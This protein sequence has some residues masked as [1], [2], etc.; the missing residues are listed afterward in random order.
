MNRCRTVLTRLLIHGRS[1]RGRG[2]RRCH[3]AA[4]AV[5]VERVELHGWQ[6]GSGAVPILK[7]R[8]CEVSLHEVGCPSM[9][10]QLNHVAI[11]Q[12]ANM[13]TCEGIW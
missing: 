9:R 7:V 4:V 11:C 10:R 12:H 13:D 8:I 2:Y 3:G 5:A 1:V 6:W